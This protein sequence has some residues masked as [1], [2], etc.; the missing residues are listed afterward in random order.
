MKFLAQSV[1]VAYPDGLGTGQR[2]AGALGSSSL[3]R[4]VSHATL[5][6]DSYG[7]PDGNVLLEVVNYSK[8]EVP[9]VSLIILAQEPPPHLHS[10]V[11]HELLRYIFHN[12]PADEES[13]TIFVPSAAPF[14]S[15]D[16]R[17]N[18]AG[19]RLA[20]KLVINDDLSARSQ[21][22][23]E[24]IDAPQDLQ[25]KDEFLACLVHLM[26]V[27]GAPG[28][29]LLVPVRRV[30]PQDGALV[31]REKDCAFQAIAHLGGLLAQ[32]LALEFSTQMMDRSLP[33]SFITRDARKPGEWRD[34]YT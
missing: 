10:C 5:S 26:R 17:H 14:P 33:E 24:L 8:G 15:V 18:T 23:G 13:F 1:L 2:I 20:H 12:A 31:S 22:F 21:M 34:L 9:M 16:S 4:S 27:M 3:D 29:I 11:A 32:W 7:L 6:L 19:A 28:V 30:S 25:P